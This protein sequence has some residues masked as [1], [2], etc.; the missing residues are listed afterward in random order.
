[1]VAGRQMRSPTSR[2]TTARSICASSRRHGGAAAGPRRARVGRL[3]RALLV[4]RMARRLSYLYGTPD[5]RRTMSGRRR[6]RGRHVAPTDALD[7]R[8]RRRGAAG[9]S[10]EKVVYESF[11]GEP[12]HAYLYR[13]RTQA[14]RAVPGHLWIHGGPTSQFMDTFQ[15]Q[16]QSSSRPGTSSCFP[17]YAAVPATGAASRT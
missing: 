8:G 12:I 6:R 7:A 5:A 3:R 15:P 17:I 11:D 9:R 16:V 2:I 1:M 4:A 14:E 13:P 10:P